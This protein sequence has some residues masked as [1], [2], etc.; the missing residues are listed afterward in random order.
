MSVILFDNYREVI[1]QKIKENSNVKGYKSKLAEALKIQS[2]YLSRVIAGTS[3]LTMEQAASLCDIWLLDKTES[4][5]FLTLV[6]LER[7]GSEVLR[8]RLL[9]MLD[10]IRKSND[11]MPKVELKGVEMDFA[12]AYDYFSF[13][14]LPTI[15]SALE[16]EEL[17]DIPALAKRLGQAPEVIENGLNKLASMNLVRK[18][19]TGWEVVEGTFLARNTRLHGSYHS[20]IRNKAAEVM[21]AGDTDGRYFTAVFCLKQK[22]Y[23]QVKEKIYNLVKDVESLAGAPGNEEVVAFTL[24]FFRFGRS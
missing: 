8:S 16:V 11:G 14:L 6:N 15:R 7:A 12:N 1:H 21:L 18:S 24:D 13:W 5:Y 2:S 9:Q 22:D 10:S 19:T 23:L 4:E 20:A 3:D 17:R